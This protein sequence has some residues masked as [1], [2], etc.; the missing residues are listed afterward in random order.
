M[1]VYRTD[2]LSEL[3]L[4]ETVL[5]YAFFRYGIVGLTALEY[6][7]EEQRIE[8]SPIHSENA[9]ELAHAH[10]VGKKGHGCRKRLAKNARIVRFPG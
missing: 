4:N 8:P 10:V 6:Q 7:Q 9:F 5:Q 3:G 2:V 1:S